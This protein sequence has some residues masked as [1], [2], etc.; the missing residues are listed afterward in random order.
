MS[1]IPTYSDYIPTQAL[2]EAALTAISTRGKELLPLKEAIAD[3]EKLIAERQRVEE[4]I[5]VAQEIYEN[6]GD[7]YGMRIGS[8]PFVAQTEDGGMWVSGWFYVGNIEDDDD[9]ADDSE[10]LDEGLLH[11]VSR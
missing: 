3:I 11:C 7:D 2:Y 5:D 8:P 4:V 9:D 1:L 10:R 6:N